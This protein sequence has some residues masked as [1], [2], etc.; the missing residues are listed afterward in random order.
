[1]SW[2][3]SSR[4]NGNERRPYG[5]LV[6]LGGA[7]AGLSLLII[8]AGAAATGRTP[9]AFTVEGTVTWIGGGDSGATLEVGACPIDEPA[10]LCPSLHRTTVAADGSYSLAL[11]TGQRRTWNVFAAVF[12]ARSFALSPPTEVTVPRSPHDA[13]PFTISTRA[14]GTRI[15]DG[16]GNPF[17]EG[18]ASV[19]AIP[20]SMPGYFNIA[21]ADANGDAV[22]LVDP[23]VEYG[24]NAFALNT[25]WPDP[26]V[27]PDGTEFHFSQNSVTAFGADIEE[28]TTFVIAKPPDA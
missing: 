15:V 19:M 22:L 13:F 10:P 1:M 27:S 25:G 8:P 12:V 3:R 11:P 14:V 21:G 6:A 24:V 23:G 28:G 16:E 5:G 9:P 17:P 2:F 26:W 7:L 18:T 4:R 20:T